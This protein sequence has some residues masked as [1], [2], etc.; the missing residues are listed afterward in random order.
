MKIAY[1]IG[2]LLKED[3]VTRVLLAL[4]D[5]AQ[6]RGIESIIIT[7]WAE[8]LTI[9]PVPVIQ[10]PSVKFPLYKE[11]RIALP[12]AA[13]KFGKKLDEFKP[14]II[15]LHSPDTIAWAALKYAKKNHVPIIATYHTEFG[16][17]LSY[18]HLAFLEP[19]LWII[20]RRLYKQMDFTMT[21]SSVVSADLTSRRIPNVRTTPWGVDLPRFSVSFRS[22]QWRQEILK[23]ENKTILLFISRLT[24]EK[25][26]RTLA[27]AYNLL[28]DKRQ[29]FVMVIGG[30]G[31]S[32]QE[33]EPMMPGAIFLGALGG[34]ELSKVYASADIFVFPSTTETFGNVTIEAMAS[35]LVPVVADAGGSKALVRDGEN[36]FKTKPKDAQDVAEKVSWLLDDPQLR[37]KMKNAALLF[38]KDFTW[39]KVFNIILQM[40]QKLL[41]H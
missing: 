24:W 28:K 22:D 11:Y 9:S 5:E 20:L 36:G 25:D 38:S 17:Y 18:Y 3:G 34:T 10:V 27:A 29:D 32:R 26:L 6:K 39:E 14:D 21:P 19:L 31:P 12:G 4:I 40:Y 1:F 35:G 13:A 23:G 33:L 41:N 2:A 7:G 16:R 37:E 8:D 15:H 30:D